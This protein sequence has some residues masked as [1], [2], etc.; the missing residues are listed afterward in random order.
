MIKKINSL[1][2]SLLLLVLF[3]ANLN[4][5]QTYVGSDKCMMCHNNVN[6]KLG[7][8]IYAEHMKTGHPYKLNPVNGA[9]PTYPA[10]TTP[11]I[12]STPPNTTWNDFAYVIGGYGWKARFVKKDGRVFTSDPQAQFNI[13]TGGWVSYNLNTETKYNYNCFKCHTTGAVPTG[14]WTGNEAEI[15]GTFS[16][17]GI[18]CEGCHGPGS[19]HMANPVGVKP[20]VSGNDLQITKCGECHQRGGVTNAIP[21]GGGYIQHHEQINEMRASKHGDGVGADL[22]CASCHDAHIALKYPGAAGE[23]LKAIKVN[24]Q[25][26]HTDK[27]ILVNGTPKSIDCIDCHMPAVGKSAVAVQTGNG[28]RGDIKTHIWSINTEAFPRD[29]MF[30]SDKATVKLDAN[31]HA[32]VTLDFV[33]LKCHTN[34]DVTW[35]SGYAKDIHTKGITVDVNDKTEIPSNFNLAQNYPNPFN[36]T[37]TINFALPKS[38]QVK[39]SVYNINGELIANLIDNMMP[40]GNHKITFDASRLSSGVYIYTINTSSFSSSKKMVLMK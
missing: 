28:F 23:G 11:G 12:H 22:T 30:T 20:P 16:E 5:A 19:E 8:N 9:E 33:C 13:E 7:Y 17:P 14:S 4:F 34:Q 18:R 40:A 35:A 39:L 3:F 10:N 24:C 31:G 25:T 21:A 6:S 2:L 26:C 27:Q 38:E 36:P 29:S 15:A 1:F 32:A 37:T